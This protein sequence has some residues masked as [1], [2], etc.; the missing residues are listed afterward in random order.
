MFV[1]LCTKPL[2]VWYAKQPFLLLSSRL[3]F[4][5]ASVIDLFQADPTRKRDPEIVVMI[6]PICTGTGQGRQFTEARERDLIVKI[7]IH[8]SDTVSDLSL[9]NVGRT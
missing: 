3:P 6:I 9:L 7:V 1:L 4:H 8:I 5:S 2:P